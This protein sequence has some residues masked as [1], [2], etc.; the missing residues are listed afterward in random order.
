MFPRLA[1]SCL[2]HK[3]FYT[4]AAMLLFGCWSTNVCLV[5]LEKEKLWNDVFLR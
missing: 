3:L 4:T 5:L 2:I 1:F